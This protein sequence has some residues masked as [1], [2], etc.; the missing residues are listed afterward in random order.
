VITKPPKILVI[1]S[2]ITELKKVEDFLRNVFD[3]YNLEIKYFNKIY[4]CIS[5]AVINAIKHGNKNDLSKQV[6]IVID[7]NNTEINIEIEDEGEGFDLTNVNNPTLR[8]NINKESGRGIFII[9]NL[10]EKIEYNQKGN[11]VQLKM[12]CK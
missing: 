10:S 11:L 4:L 7:C 1:N 5:E 9:R 2:D 8:E 6:S 3:E 12:E